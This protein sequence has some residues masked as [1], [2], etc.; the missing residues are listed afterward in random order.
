SA[1][2]GFAGKPG[3]EDVRHCLDPLDT[4]A[5]SALACD[6]EY[7]QLSEDD[8][9]NASRVEDIDLTLFPLALGPYVIPY[10]FSS[11]PRA[12]D[13]TITPAKL[14][15]T[16][17]LLPLEL[18]DRVNVLSTLLVSH[19]TEL[20]NRYS[21]LVNRKSRTQKKLD[22]KMKYVKEFRSEVTTLGEKLDKVQ[23]GCSFLN[24]ENRE[25]H[26]QN[27]ALS[28]EVKRLQN[29]IALERSKSQEYKDV[30]EGLRTEIT[31]FVGSG[32]E[33]LGRRLLSSDEFNAALAL[34]VSLGIAFG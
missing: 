7:D 19:G 25:L 1:T 28:E 9:S 6:L 15:R 30:I 33:C 24:Q 18:V 31:Q 22:R 8:F 23:E 27:N 16:K 32:V 11:N 4:L 26:S 34:V 17:S 29:E 3:T 12:L 14:R 2:G 13:H 21:Y 10:L 20:N 5:R